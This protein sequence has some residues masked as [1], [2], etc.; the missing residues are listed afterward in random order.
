MTSASGCTWSAAS[1][2]P[3]WITITDGA[4]GSGSGT[5]TYSVAE[6]TAADPRTGTLT[7]AEQTFT[8]VQSGTTP[9][10]DFGISNNNPDI[11]ETVTFTAAPGIQ[12]VSWDFGGENCDGQDPQVDCSSVTGDCR[13]MQWEWLEAG[14]KAVTMVSAAAGEKTHNLIVNNTGS[15]PVSCDATGPPGVSFTM[16]PNPALINETVTFTDTSTGAGPNAPTDWLWTVRNGGQVTLTNSSR[17]FTHQFDVD[18]IYQVELEASNCGY[19]EITTRNLDIRPEPEEVQGWVVPSAVRTAGLNNTVWK[20]DL[21]I[22]NEANRATP[23]DMVF[24]PADTNNTQGPLSAVSIVVPPKHTRI[25]ANVMSLFPGVPADGVKGSIWVVPESGGSTQFVIGSR[26]YNDTPEGTFGQFVPAISLDS[27]FNNVLYFTGLAEN[28]SFRTNVGLVNLE[29]LRAD[30]IAL[31]IFDERG[32]RLGNTVYSAV[33]PGSS[34]QIVRIARAAGITSDLDSFSLKIALNG[35]N[36]SA[37]ASVVDN[38][39]GDPVFLSPGIVGAYTCHVP[40]LAHLPGLNSSIWR[41][42]ITY[43]NPTGHH[44][45]ADFRYFPDDHSGWVPTTSISLS[46]ME[47]ILM[48]DVIGSISHPGGANSKGH[49]LVSGTGG[50]IAPLTSA[51]TYNL[52][53]AGG[54][55][56]QNVFVFGQSNLIGQDQSGYMPGVCNSADGEIGSRT[57]IGIVNAGT[58]GLNAE[59]LVTF[60]TETGTI[61]VSSV[62]VDLGPDEMYQTN[63]FDL[64]GIGGYDFCGTARVMTLSGGPVAAYASIVDNRTQDP[65]MVPAV[66]AE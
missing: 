58:R 41:S 57:N 56:G 33:L 20:T 39:T 53:P 19:S 23:I 11:G 12:P 5:V 18:G 49:I 46:P 32:N 64:L 16:A 31:T 13:T 35:E 43:F 44:L 6:N 25:I 4:D 22:F 36:V 66:P 59:V 3:A 51:R 40:G 37:Y 26:T 63:L 54:T 27:P 15:C 60:W 47:A 48:T 61:V 1:N 14:T 38:V 10:A 30:G 7:I 62:S 34:T 2:E 17:V 65:I 24:L 55:F 52:D 50:R 9:A 45:D 28:D 21:S 8:V 42:D 29:P